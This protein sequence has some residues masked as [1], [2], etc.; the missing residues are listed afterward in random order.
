MLVILA[1]IGWL[2]W[3]FSSVI[4]YLNVML[5]PLRVLGDGGMVKDK[6]EDWEM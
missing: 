3:C 1:N 5:R 4:V 6:D 2:C